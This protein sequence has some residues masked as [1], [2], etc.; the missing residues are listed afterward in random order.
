MR[1]YERPTLTHVGSFSSKTGF[2][3][4]HG[5]DGLILQKN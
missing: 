5:N 3:A 2:L 1:V 4:R